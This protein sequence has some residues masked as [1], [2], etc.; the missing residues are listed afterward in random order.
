[1][2]VVKIENVIIAKIKRYPTSKCCKWCASLAGVYEYPDVTKDVYRRHQNCNCK[3][4]FIPGKGK[5]QDVWTKEWINES[6]SSK[7]KLRKM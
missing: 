5:K 7:I 6:E 4:E 2:D 3:L 1:M